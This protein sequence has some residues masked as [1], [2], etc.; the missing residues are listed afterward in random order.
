[1]VPY[2]GVKIQELLDYLLH[3]SRL[4]QPSE[5]PSPM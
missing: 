3:G 5:T 2:G 4:A 1:M